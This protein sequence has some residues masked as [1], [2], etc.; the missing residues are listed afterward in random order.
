MLIDQ[1]NRLIKN[2]L[3]FID[4]IAVEYYLTKDV[5]ARPIM[6]GI[7]SCRRVCQGG[8]AALAR[9]SRPVAAILNL[10]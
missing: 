7:I 4:D 5:R 3:V 8:G 2:I 10:R 1:H 9:R 6:A